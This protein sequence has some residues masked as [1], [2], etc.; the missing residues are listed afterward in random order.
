MK[1]IYAPHDFLTKLSPNLFYSFKTY[2]LSEKH[3]DVNTL[4]SLMKPLL[5]HI[6]KKEKRSRQKSRQKNN[7]EKEAKWGDQHAVNKSD[8]L[9]E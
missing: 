4:I 1:N 9:T 6:K 2:R 3:D 8:W 5:S 7:K